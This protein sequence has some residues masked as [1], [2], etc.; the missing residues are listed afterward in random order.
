MEELGIDGTPGSTIAGLG[1]GE[2]LALWLTDGSLHIAQAGSSLRQVDGS[3]VDGKG[4]WAGR[5]S[6]TVMTIISQ[7][8]PDGIDAVDRSVPCLGTLLLQQPAAHLVNG[9]GVLRCHLLDS[10]DGSHL[11]RYLVVVPGIRG[12]AGIVVAAHL[13]GKD[14]IFL[15]ALHILPCLLVFTM[16]GEDDGCQRLL[17]D[18]L[19]LDVFLQQGYQ[20]V[21]GCLDI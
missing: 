17:V 8:G 11:G 21:V 5:V 9:F 4:G 12:T 2:G 14:G 15:Q 10:L 20:V 16:T 6:K 19:A 1:S 13:L 18:G 3:T 7:E